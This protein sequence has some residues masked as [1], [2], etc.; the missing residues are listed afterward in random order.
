VSPTGDLFKHTD[1]EDVEYFHS[2]FIEMLETH[3]ERESDPEN[4]NKNCE[5][6]IENL[7]SNLN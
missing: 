7:W 3:H 1:Y 6:I 5:Q 2:K 4:G